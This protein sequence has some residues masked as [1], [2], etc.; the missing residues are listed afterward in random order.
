MTWKNF[1]IPETIVIPVAAG[2]VL[3]ALIRN[4]LFALDVIWVILG[5]LLLILALALMFW[6]V[7]EAGLQ[8]LETPD[9][10]LMSGP[11]AFSRNPMYLSWL[12]VYLAFFFLNRSLWVLIRFFVALPLTH[13][14]AV[15]LEERTLK[16]KFGETYEHY[17]AK[18]RRYF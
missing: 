9:E 13:F 6:A 18:V 11:Y 7:R 1:P 2:L 14:T 10:L 4:P 3:D 8:N 17:Q 12:S 16:N 5:L 15:L